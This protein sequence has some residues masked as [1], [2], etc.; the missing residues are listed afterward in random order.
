MKKY[1]YNL[2]KFFSFPLFV[3]IVIIFLYVKSDPF[4]DFGNYDN[5]SWKYHFQQLGDLSTKKLLNSKTNYNSFILGS[6]RTTGIYACYLNKNIQN[7]EFF[8]YGSFNEQIGGIYSKMKLLDSLNHRMDN[9]IIYIDTDQTFNNYGNTQLTDH[10]LLNNRSRIKSVYD[11]FRSFMMLNFDKINILRD[12]PVSGKVYPNWN[13]D[14]ITNDPNHICTDSVLSSYPI[15]KYVNHNKYKTLID[16]LKNS[17]KMHL[18]SDIQGYKKKQISN[19][20]MDILTNI[21][22]MLKKHNSNYYVIVT[23]LYDQ[24]KFNAA[25][26]KILNQIFEDKIY[27]FSGINSITSNEYNFPDVKHFIPSISKSILDSIIIS[28]NFVKN[29]SL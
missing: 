4:Q 6:S 15:N 8:H 14:K 25:D 21:K 2:I 10:Y 3:L 13:S 18:R 12:R 19:N 23:P 5:Y 26:S 17:G 20:E 29:T 7:S 16:S 28:N 1:L 27:D 24:L 22:Q 9:L 11:H